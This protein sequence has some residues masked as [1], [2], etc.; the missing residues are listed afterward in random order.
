MENKKTLVIGGSENPARYSNMAIH[1]LRQ[2]SVEVVSVAKKTVMILDV[3]IQTQFPASEN[4]DII[5]LYVG[6][7]RQ[8]EYYNQ[9]LK[10]KPDRVIFNPGTENKE[11]AEIP[12][13]KGVETI[14][15][16]TLVLLGVGQY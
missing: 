10:L 2:R 12:E 15:A 3:K 16:C 7:Q 11:F 5:T 6:K 9:L 8:P 4:I 1:S 14:E 13:S